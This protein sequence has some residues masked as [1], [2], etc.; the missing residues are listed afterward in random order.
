VEESEKIRNADE[1]LEVPYLKPRIFVW[2]GQELQGHQWVAVDPPVGGD[3]V[4]YGVF[5]MRALDDLHCAADADDV[6]Y[7]EIPDTAWGDYVGSTW[8]RSN[9]RSIRRDYP[10][11]VVTVTGHHSF[12]TLLVPAEAQIPARLFE[13]I[14]A[15]AESAFYDED[16]WS[17]LEH[18][19]E[20]EQWD[21]TGR[22]DFRSEIREL[23][24]RVDS[25]DDVAELDSDEYVNE[26]FYEA[27]SNCEVQW[28]AE[29]ATGGAWH[30]FDR[31]AEAAWAVV[32][33]RRM[34]ELEAWA[35][36]LSAPIPGQLCLLP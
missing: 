30:G 14:E 20:Q 5:D 24:Q 8:A 27:W 17:A 19:L 4:R 7:I 2:Q 3:S 23:A 32:Q 18:E 10:D 35:R 29:T 9:A 36:E 6:R 1:L 25:D 31:A 12:E 26:L 11:D 16:D 22:S 34:A 33:L 28:V 21:D 13:A 15:R